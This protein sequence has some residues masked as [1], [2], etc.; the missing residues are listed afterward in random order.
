MLRLMAR[1]TR[2]EAFHHA[3]G[4]AV[5]R[6]HVLYLPGYDPMVPRRYRELYRSEGEKQARISDYSLKVTGLTG[7]EN[8]TWLAE[9]EIDGQRAEARMEFLLWNDIVQDSM[10]QSILA[11]YLL[12][13]RTA[14]IY[15]R[16]GTLWALFRLRPTPMI[17]ALYPVVMLIVYLLAGIALGWAVLAI[18]TLFLPWPIG[19]VAAAA[20]LAAFLMVLRRYDPHL[21]V[22]YL[23]HDYAFSAIPYGA[24]PDVLVERERTFVARLAEVMGSDADEVL[25]VGHSSGAH[26]AVEVVAAYLRDHTLR[27][28]GPKLALL[29]LGGVIPMISFLPEAKVL[30]RDL[31]QLSQVEDLTWIDISAPGDGASFALAD[32][33]HVSGV[34]P[35]EAVK[36]WPKI[37][38]AAFSETLSP[39]LDQATKWRFFRRHFQYLCC[40]DR[41]RGYDYFQITAGPLYLRD[42]YAERGSTAS[43]IETVHSPYRDM[44]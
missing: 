44:A 14:W 19:L 18:L 25:V 8:Y 10:D 30:R 23:M 37:I 12:M 27:E 28:D 40:F 4:T 5:R 36:I 24:T 2:D 32:P 17:A 34:A 9:T 33:V 13:V 29:T 20:T 6:R 39:E 31:C 38:S 1:M 35:P 22:F 11:T 3:Y 21:F 43:R 15:I 42:R 26:V 41:P 16:T 7:Q